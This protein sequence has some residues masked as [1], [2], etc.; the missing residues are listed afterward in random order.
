MSCSHASPKAL[1]ISLSL[2]PIQTHR[3]PT[4]DFWRVSSGRSTDTIQP[5]FV[6]KQQL[7]EMFESHG[8]RAVDQQV[9]VGC[10][11]EL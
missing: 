9:L 11:A 10:L 8:A 6:P 4:N 5:F 1:L 7:H 2:G 3:N